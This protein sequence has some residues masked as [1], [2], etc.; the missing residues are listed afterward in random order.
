[1]RPKAEPAAAPFIAVAEPKLVAARSA[2]YIVQRLGVDPAPGAAE[3]VTC[4]HIEAGFALRHAGKACRNAITRKTF[5]AMRQEHVEAVL[6]ARIQV[7]SK[8]ISVQVVVFAAS[9]A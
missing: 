8:P 7:Q 4:A 5:E 1:M 9:S 2:G 6:R 3:L